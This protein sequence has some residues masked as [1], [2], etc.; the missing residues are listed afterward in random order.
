MTQPSLRELPGF[1][2]FAAFSLVDGHY[3]LNPVS[4]ALPSVSGIYA[5]TQG[6]VVR[7]LGSAASFRSRMRDYARWQAN[8]GGRTQRPIHLHLREALVEGPVDVMFRH[9]ED[10]LGEWHGLPV[11]LLLGIE[12]G[13]IRKLN[14]KWNRRGRNSV[15][16]AL[17]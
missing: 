14:P 8:G 16:S 11:H 5:F 15:T 13:L 12:G 1:E 9:F 3:T 7:Y 6:S 10:E 4:A 2:R 17:P